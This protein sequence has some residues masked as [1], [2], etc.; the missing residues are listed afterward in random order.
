[1]GAA[2]AQVLGAAHRPVV[3]ALGAA[4]AALAAVA[5]AA[6]AAAAHQH[7]TSRLCSRRESVLPRAS[8]PTRRHDLRVRDQQLRPVVVVQRHL[9]SAV[10]QI[11]AATTAPARRSG[12]A[13]RRRRRR[14][15]GRAR[16][17]RPRGGSSARGADAAARGG[18][19]SGA[20]ARAGTRRG[21]ASAAAGGAG[22][23]QKRSGRRGGGTARSAAV[24]SGGGR[25]S[26]SRRDAARILA[27]AAGA[28]RSLELAVR[29]PLDLRSFARRSRARRICHVRRRRAGERRCDRTKIK[30]ISRSG[31]AHPLEHRLELLARRQPLL[32][33]A[34]DLR[35]D[36]EPRRMRRRL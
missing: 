35:E 28:D 36:V 29:G 15:R 6:A 25:S 9:L 4:A 8:L 18:A 19:S 3:V 1:M 10:A 17:E 33:L 32:L 20:G 22:A 26:A 11:H 23:R 24:R 13:A 21:I 30:C 12:R 34:D 16:R 27:A 14:R 31:V 7:A 2:S 5:A